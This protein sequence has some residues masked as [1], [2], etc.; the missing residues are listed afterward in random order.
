MVKS[1]MAA[2]LSAILA[3]SLWS[4]VPKAGK[5]IIADCRRLEVSFRA[6]LRLGDV[7]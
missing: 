1:L 2:G 7:D 5:K 6:A 4:A 3:V